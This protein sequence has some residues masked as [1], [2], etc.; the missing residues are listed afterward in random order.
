MDSIR[1]VTTRD[2]Q[3]EEELCI[4]YGHKL[5]FS[6]VEGV[7]KEYPNQGPQENLDEWGGLSTLDYDHT[8]QIIHSANPFTGGNP[9]EILSEEDLPFVRYKLPPDEEEPDAVRTSMS[10]PTIAIFVLLGL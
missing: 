9:E 7:S 4:F 3:S 2:I 6:P 10:T 1:Y 8:A 5:W